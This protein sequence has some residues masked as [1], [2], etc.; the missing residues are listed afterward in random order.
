MLISFLCLQLKL[1]FNIFEF[2]QHSF[3]HFIFTLLLL[4]FNLLNFLFQLIDLGGSFLILLESCLQSL[5]HLTLCLFL[6]LGFLLLFLLQRFNLVLEFI[7]LRSLIL[8]L[9]GVTICKI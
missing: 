7:D 8:C 2:L 9:L 4:G 6:L 3:S 1:G 5:L